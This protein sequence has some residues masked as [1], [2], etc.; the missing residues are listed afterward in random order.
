MVFFLLFIAVG[1]PPI[2]KYTASKIFATRGRTEIRV[3]AG[4]TNPSG[5]AVFRIILCLIRRLLLCLIRLP[6]TILGVQC[7]CTIY[8]MNP[9]IHTR[10]QHLNRT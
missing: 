10:K 8:E 5:R 6:I 7:I 4:L 2:T 3:L 1:E 9:T